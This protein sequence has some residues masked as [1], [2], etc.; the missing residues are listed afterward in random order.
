[1]VTK[2]TKIS[3]CQSC[4]M[5]LEKLMQL[6]F[7]P[8]FLDLFP[9]FFF[10]F[11]VARPSPLFFSFLPKSDTTTTNKTTTSGPATK[12]AFQLLLLLLT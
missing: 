1:M 2:E 8:I 5:L 4:S 11:C 3:F 10:P 6:F 7:V 9:L 12:V